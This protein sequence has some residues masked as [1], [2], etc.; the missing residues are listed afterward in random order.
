MASSTG[1]SGGKVRGGAAASSLV[2]IGILLSRVAGLVRESVFAHFF[3]V[4]MFADV[5]RAGLRMPN[6]LQNLLGEGTLSASFI[7]VYSEL[8]EQGRERDRQGVDL[9]PER[10]ARCIGPDV[11][12][13]AVNRGQ[14]K[15]DQR[16]K[17]GKERPVEMREQTSIDDHG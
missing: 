10:R 11:P 1:T 16:D 17:G 3:G 6:A 2:A 4:T 15:Q 7:P 13:H 14:A 12:R 5:F 9:T 8:L